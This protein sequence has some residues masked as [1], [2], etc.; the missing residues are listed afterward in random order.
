MKVNLKISI[1]DW[2]INIIKEE[3][4]YSTHFNLLTIRKHSSFISSS[5]S[6]NKNCE[7]EKIFEKRRKKCIL[8]AI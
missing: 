3:S 5:E 2:R 7:Q 4:K 6:E 1:E 8:K